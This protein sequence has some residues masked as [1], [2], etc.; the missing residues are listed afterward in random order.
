MGISRS[1][2][3]LLFFTKPSYGRFFADRILYK[4]KEGLHVKSQLSV[5]I[6]FPRN[7][8]TL[9]VLFQND[10]GKR[11]VYPPHAQRTWPIRGCKL[12]SPYKTLVSNPRKLHCMSF[13]DQ[14]RSHLAQM[15]STYDDFRA[16]TFR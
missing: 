5:L 3:G 10:S 7:S 11:K 4:T 9:P 1:I 15:A 16:Q 2:G 14:S 8:H 6:L 13:G 12:P